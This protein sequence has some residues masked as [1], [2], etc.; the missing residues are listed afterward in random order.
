MAKKSDQE[1][2]GDYFRKKSKDKDTPESEEVGDVRVDP[3][4]VAY[5]E[6]VTKDQDK[7][8]DI[9]KPGLVIEG[10]GRWPYFR[11][12]TEKRY[13]RSEV[14]EIIK[15]EVDKA[16]A[17]TGESPRTPSEIPK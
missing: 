3:H 13:T 4:L 9:K 2:M 8:H 7:P 17:E 16:L 12:A 14:N 5:W 10:T 1:I 6:D 15:Q 11:I